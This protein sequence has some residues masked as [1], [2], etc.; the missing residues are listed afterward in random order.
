MERYRQG[1]EK[2]SVEQVRRAAVDDV[3]P[4]R[5]AILVVG[6]AAARAQLA[7][8]GPVHDLDVSIPEP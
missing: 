7:P 8:F 1:V 6:P 4:D 3:H 5:F 2:V